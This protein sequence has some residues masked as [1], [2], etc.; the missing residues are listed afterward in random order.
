LLFFLGCVHGELFE[1]AR[2]AQDDPETMVAQSFMYI[3]DEQDNF[4]R[5]EVQKI[6]YLLSYSKKYQHL[7]DD[8]PVSWNTTKEET[9]D[10]IRAKA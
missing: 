7:L 5:D 2:D 8:L 9:M 1:V 4:K 10:Y 3:F 6:V